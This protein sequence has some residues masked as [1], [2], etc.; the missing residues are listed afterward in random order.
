MPCA[1]RRRRLH[2]QGGRGAQHSRIQPGASS[3]EVFNMGYRIGGADNVGRPALFLVTFCDIGMCP[4][5]RKKAESA[6]R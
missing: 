6:G 4:V 5:N 1:P 2:D 3:R